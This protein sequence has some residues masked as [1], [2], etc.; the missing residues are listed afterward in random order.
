MVPFVGLLLEGEKVHDKNHFWE[1]AL[2]LV[3]N[4]GLSTSD[5]KTE[6]TL[7]AIG[8][9]ICSRDTCSRSDDAKVDTPKLGETSWPTNNVPFFGWLVM[10]LMFA[11]SVSHFRKK[12]RE[13]LCAVHTMRHFQTCEHQR[14]HSQPRTSC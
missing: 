3:S 7:G 14:C 8:T 5:E 12:K 10:R 4:R 6:T 2:D 13:Q 11:R 1:N 9:Y